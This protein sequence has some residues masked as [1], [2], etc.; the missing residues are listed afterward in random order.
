MFVLESTEC[1]GTDQIVIDNKSCVISLATLE[2]EP[3]MVDG[4]DSVYAKVSAVNF[5]GE[6][7]QSEEGNG[8]YHT[9]VPDAPVNVAEVV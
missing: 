5:Y 3:Y 1:D 8:A 7:A 6:S 2:V 4:G 9:Q